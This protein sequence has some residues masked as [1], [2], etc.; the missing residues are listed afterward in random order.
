MTKYILDVNNAD[1]FDIFFTENYDDWRFSLVDKY[2][3]QITKKVK[4]K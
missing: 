3:R 4:F 1:M 2:N